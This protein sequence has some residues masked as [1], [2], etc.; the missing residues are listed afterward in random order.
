MVVARIGRPEATLGTDDTSVPAHAPTPTRVRSGVGPLRYSQ[1]THERG[2]ANE[3]GELG[4]GAE[5]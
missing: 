1:S 2:C 4:G 3:F 5:H